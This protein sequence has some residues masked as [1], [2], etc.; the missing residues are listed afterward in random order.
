L[1]G[2]LPPEPPAEVDGS[3]NPVV[4]AAVSLKAPLLLFGMMELNGI[5]LLKAIQRP[6]DLRS[7][8]RRAAGLRFGERAAAALRIAVRA[9]VVTSPDPARAAFQRSV[10]HPVG[11]LPGNIHGGERHDGR[12]V[13]DLTRRSESGT[14]AGAIPG[15]ALVIPTDVAGPMRADAGYCMELALAV[16]VERDVL[17]GQDPP[18]LF[19]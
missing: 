14:V 12:A 18:L 11:G 5:D 6:A 13:D 10:T 2:S 3:I 17:I 7:P 15:L 1:V 4:R 8:G 9:R 19:L 16:S